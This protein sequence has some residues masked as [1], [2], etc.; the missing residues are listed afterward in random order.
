[1]GIGIAPVLKGKVT[2]SGLLIPSLILGISCFVAS[3][4]PAQRAARML[5]AAGMR[6]L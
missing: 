3:F 4:Y 1:M 6:E 5:P 2:L